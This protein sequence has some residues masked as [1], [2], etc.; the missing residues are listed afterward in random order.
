MITTTPSLDIY[1]ASAGSGKTFTLVKE[2]LKKLLLVEATDYY[3]QILAI[4]FTNKAVGEMKKRIVE[5]LV[6]FADENAKESPGDMQKLIAEEIGLSHSL[7]QKKSKH[8]LRHLLHDYSGFSVETIDKF[9]HRIIRSFA[10]DLKLNSNFEVSLDSDILLEEAVDR[11]IAQAG[12]DRA[13]TDYLLQYTYSQLNQDKSWDIR[14]DIIKTAGLLNSETNK[15]SLD[16][17]KEHS[18]TDFQVFAKNLQNTIQENFANGQKIASDT[19]ALL[20]SM[21]VPDNAFTGSYFPKFLH[22]V[23]EDIKTAKVSDETKWQQQIESGEYVYYKKTTPES[24]KQQIDSVKNEL[25]QAFLGIKTYVERNKVYQLV[26]RELLPMALINLV[27]NER[28]DIQKEQNLLLIG[29]FNYLLHEQVKDQPAPFIYE[30][31]GERYRHF[32]IDEFQDTS[33]LQWENM[34]PLLDNALSQGFEIGLPGS[35]MLVGDA[36][37]SIYRWR[38]GYPQQFIGLT[39]ED[40]PFQIE[41]DQKKVI[42]LDTNYRSAENIIHFN[43]RFFTQTADIFKNETY[44]DL[45]KVGNQQKKN[46]KEGGYVHIEMLPKPT[47]E[48]NNNTL[49]QEKVV[50]L[51]ENLQLDPSV[52]L[53]DI[54]ILVRKNSQG[55]LISEALAENNI[56]M[57]S[58]ETLLL[59]NS[60]QVNALLNA[61]RLLLYPEDKEARVK[62]CY[63]LYDALSIEEDKH[64]F[65]SKLMEKHS[66]QGFLKALASNGIE[67]DL[68]AVTQAGLYQTF[69]LLIKKLEIDKHNNAYLF[70]FM[71]FVHHYEQTEATTKHQFF[72]Y[73]AVKSDRL[74]IPSSKQSEAVQIMTIHKAKGLEFPIVIVPF[75]N[76]QIGDL[77]KTSSW[78]PWQDDKSNFEEV[79]VSVNDSL[80]KF[81]EHYHQHYDEIFE[82]EVLDELNNVY[83]AFTRASQELYIITDTYRNSKSAYPL[84]LQLENFVSNQGAPLGEGE[85][86]TFGERSKAV[87]KE[88]E[89]NKEQIITPSYT[90]TDANLLEIVTVDADQWGDKAKEAIE[91]GTELHDILEQIETKEDFSK[92]FHTL[93]KQQTLAKEKYDKLLRTIR[94]VVEH[95]DLQHLFKSDLQVRTEM[96]IV[97]AD[98]QIRR[99]D[100]LNFHDDNTLTL[101]DYKTGAPKASDILQIKA[102]AEALEEMGMKL[103]EK[104]LVYIDSNTVVVNKV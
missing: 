12:Q 68:E 26:L 69:E 89:Q 51:I 74:S 90:I 23:A 43:N 75:S 15:T 73:W 88:E 9:N 24:E 62:L 39:K 37:Q 21:G 81:D 78:L 30:R 38:G 102:Y 1:D 56:P 77:G 64:D 10:K 28:S 97:T 60:K 32:F 55:V 36:K 7:I 98:K 104:L 59:K 29:D 6:A 95:K 34:L 71:E 44:K 14:R 48:R 84:S 5:Q 103:K 50:E 82:T 76:S 61:M 53:S 31:L 67:I 40:L 33:Q 101:V 45:Y 54:C 4:T 18:L 93:E 83:V 42:H 66:L 11:L 20:E 79:Y 25:N 8:I 86:Y 49:H 46:K 65:L 27:G 99:M 41:P 94:N 3:K 17:L 57:I 22:K 72:D 63:Y 16:K 87:T 70:S 58:S 92:Y 52:S 85:T 91:Y 96:D 80:T 100:R 47:Q 19:L 2:Y 13:I 35:A